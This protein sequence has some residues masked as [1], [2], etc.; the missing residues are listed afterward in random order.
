MIAPYQV[1]EISNIL[2][3]TKDG[4]LINLLW[5]PDISRNI[6][7]NI[8]EDRKISTATFKNKKG[9][10]NCDIQNILKTDLIER[11]IIFQNNTIEKKVLKQL[12]NTNQ[13]KTITQEYSKLIQK[14]R[15]N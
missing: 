1:F 11:E 3:T 4:N 5:I 13:K 7:M 14:K 10:F 2:P 9:L 15:R 12:L 8:I 6:F